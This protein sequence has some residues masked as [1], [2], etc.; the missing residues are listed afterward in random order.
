MEAHCRSGSK[1]QENSYERQCCTPDL[2]SA[3]IYYKFCHSL[4]HGYKKWNN[5]VPICDMRLLKVEQIASTLLHE[6]NNKIVSKLREK[7]V[8]KMML[9]S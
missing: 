7:V 4:S 8:V 3:V 6:T 2:K 5:L 9:H 1:L